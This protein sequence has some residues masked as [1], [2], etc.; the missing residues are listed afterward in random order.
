MK[1]IRNERFD[2]IGLG[3]DYLDMYSLGRYNK[4]SLRKLRDI[5]LSYEYKDGIKGL[6]DIDVAVG[7]RRIN[8]F[9]LT[10]NHEDRYFRARDEG[11]TDKY[12]DTLQPFWEALRLRERGY[13]VYLDWRQDKHRIGKLNV[14]HGLYT[15]KYPASKHLEVFNYKSVIFGH[16]HVYQ[17][18]RTGNDAIGQAVG[19]LMDMN[20]PAFHYANFQWRKR[21]SNSFA[22]VYTKPNGHFFIDV[23]QSIDNQFVYNGRLY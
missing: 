15:T 1:L 17:S 22:V 20:N 6:D 10:G 13:K 4:G 18:Y 2:T 23:I 5:D 16:A 3:G 19:G 7:G 11:D 12:G 8:K 9:W 21:W 14:V